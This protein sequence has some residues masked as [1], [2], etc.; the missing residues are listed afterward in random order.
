MAMVVAMVLARAEA[1]AVAKGEPRVV[2]KVVAM[3]ARAAQERVRARALRGGAGATREKAEAQ[4][5][6][7]RAAACLGS[8]TA[9]VGAKAE[10]AVETT[11]K[12]VKVIQVEALEGELLEAGARL[13]LGRAVASFAVGRT[14][15]K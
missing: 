9:E 11:A 14:V 2:A 3:M 10:R 13:V 12:V 4:T 1:R 7:T 5:V 15:A 6:A 8:E